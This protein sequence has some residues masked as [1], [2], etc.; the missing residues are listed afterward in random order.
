MNFKVGDKVMFNPKDMR[1]SLDFGKL[2]VDEIFVI[3]DIRD[4]HYDIKTENPRLPWTS[5]VLYKYRFISAKAKISNLPS[6][7]V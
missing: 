4:R 3:T 2:Y 5:N 6:D 1:N 7:P